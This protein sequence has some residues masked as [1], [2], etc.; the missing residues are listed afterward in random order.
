MQPTLSSPKDLVT[1]GRYPFAAVEGPS[2]VVASN[3]LLLV[4]ALISKGLNRSRIA[5]RA[6]LRWFRF[7]A[8]APVFAFS[9]FCFLDCWGRITPLSRSEAFSCFNCEGGIVVWLDF[10]EW[11]PFFF[12]A[13]TIKKKNGSTEAVTILPAIERISASPIITHLHYTS[14]LLSRGT[15][16]FGYA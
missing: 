8:E 2:R 3:L 1:P 12:V 7:C 9:R 5:C 15:A 11:V 13:F 10:A 16:C 4:G 14:W 6:A